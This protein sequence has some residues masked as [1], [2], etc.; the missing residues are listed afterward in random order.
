MRIASAALFFA[1]A[2]ASAADRI[3]SEYFPPQTRV[4]IGISLRTLLDSPLFAAAGG[5]AA[6]IPK[7]GPFLGLD[8]S[9]DLDSVIIASEGDTASAPSI[10]VVR[11]RFRLDAAGATEHA[12]VPIFEDKKGFLALVDANTA[13]AG[14]LADVKAALDRRGGAGA[15]SA[16]LAARID[17]VAGRHDFWAVGDLPEG[18]A[19]SKPGAKEMPSIDRFDFG[20]SLRDGLQLQGSVHLRSSEEAAQLA[21]MIQM[22]STMLQMQPSKSAAKFNLKADGGT[23][24]VDISIPEAELKRTV[25]EQKDLFT[26]MLGSRMPRRLGT[27]AAAPTVAESPKPPAYPISRPPSA[28]ATIVTNDRGETVQVTLPGGK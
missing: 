7:A 9:K 10:A 2:I 14:T 16:D 23:L 12:G 25:S 21:T 18:L 1:T 22:F 19:P 6:L 15:L 5:G 28:P 11:G 13:I 20:A 27:P 4:V 26:G 24:R 3:P 17:A 8:P